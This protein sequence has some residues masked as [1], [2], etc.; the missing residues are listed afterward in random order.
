MK[1]KLKT[2][3]PVHISTGINLEPFDYLIKDENIY[4]ISLP[5]AIEVISEDVP[6]APE[7]FAEWLDE[8]LFRFDSQKN[9]QYQHANKSQS[10][11]R[12]RN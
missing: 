4:R 5:K 10:K 3:T 8:Q 11:I 9:T 7:Q 6:D 12:K 1:L 2:L